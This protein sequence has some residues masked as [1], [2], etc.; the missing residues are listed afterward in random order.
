MRKA[1]NLW[2]FAKRE[3]VLVSEINALVERVP[4]ILKIGLLV[5]SLYIGV[6]FVT[7]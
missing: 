4:A 3:T 1:V 7:I 6:L 5:I 2:N